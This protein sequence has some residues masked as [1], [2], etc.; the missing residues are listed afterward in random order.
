M[1]RPEAVFSA[2]MKVADLI[3]LDY[4]LLGVLSRLG[5]RL[6]FGDA[7][8]AALCQRHGVDTETF[9]ILCKAYTLKD[10]RPSGE[11]IDTIQAPDVLRYLRLSHDYYTKTA[12]V[13]LEGALEKILEGCDKRYRQIIWKFFSDYKEELEKHFAL[14]EDRIFPYVEALLSG[15]MGAG[16]DS[17]PQDSHGEI[18]DKLD[19]LKNIVMKYLP[20]GN[21]DNIIE[22]VCYI[23]A[24]REDIVR[25]SAIED[26]ILMP[27]IDRM[28]QRYGR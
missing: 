6:G 15:G 1:S 9:L 16:R 13:A 4:R 7:T 27:L 22:T 11:V 25:H 3:D 20:E 8:V 26:N 19:D 24:L 18:E 17:I 10:Y 21:E 2:K 23:Y 5:M 28:E 14:E 12:L